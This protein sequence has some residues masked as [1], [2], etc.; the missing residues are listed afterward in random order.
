MRLRMSEKNDITHDYGE[1]LREIRSHLDFSQK[2]FAA[3]LGIAP[4]FLSELEKEKT[5]PGYNF[6]MKLAEVFNISPSWVL[7]GHGQMF[8]NE[9]NGKPVIE[10]DFGEQTDE[11]RNLLIYFEKSPLVRLSVMA[12]AS[13]FLLANEDIINRDIDEHNPGK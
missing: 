7:L 6:L 1:R 3:E 2:D 12:F 10:Q 9:K 11:I 5:K 8:L 4:S 13:K